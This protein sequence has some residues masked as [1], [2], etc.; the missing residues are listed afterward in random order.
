MIDQFRLARPNDVNLH[1]ALSDVS[2]EIEF[3]IF[4]DWGSSNTASPEFAAETAKASNL[5]MPKK[6]RVPCETLGTILER[7]GNGRSIDFL[8]IDVE[9]LDLRVLQSSDWE[10]F[11]P[12]LV[13]IEDFEFDYAAA[14]GSAIYRF[15]TS[16]RY[17]MVSRNIYT[18][19]FAADESGISLYHRSETR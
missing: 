4:H 2:G 12:S 3:F 16:K 11:R 14:S 10:R 9:A 8:N 13:A 6:I 17:K 15:L 7:H 1:L 19:I 5:D 18:S